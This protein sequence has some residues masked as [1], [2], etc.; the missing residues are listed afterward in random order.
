MCS[1]DLWSIIGRVSIVRARCNATGL[2]LPQPWG[3]DELSAVSDCVD[4][5]FNGIQF[6]CKCPR[7]NFRRQTAFRYPNLTALY[8]IGKLTRKLVVTPSRLHCS[9]RSP[10]IFA[11]FAKTF[12]LI[13][14]VCFAIATGK[15]VQGRDL[16]VMVV[17][18][19]NANGK[20]FPL[21]LH[22]AF[23]FIIIF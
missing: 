19:I 11:Q 2:R 3:D 6:S 20:S 14:F 8:S 7:H 12:L 22:T 23:Y 5:S 16:W 13:N 10:F 17:S 18:L 15:S 9:K 1:L 4:G 21:P